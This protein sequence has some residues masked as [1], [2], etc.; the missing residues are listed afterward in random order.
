MTNVKDYM[1]AQES[2]ENSVATMQMNI[3]Q[4]YDK[5]LE[6]TRNGHYVDLSK[7]SDKESRK[8][9]KD[10]LVAGLLSPLNSAV[11]SLPEDPLF[12]KNLAMNSFYGFDET[13]LSKIVEDVKEGLT[14]E[15]FQG[16]LNQTRMRHVMQERMQAPQTMLDDISTE[17]LLDSI[18]VKAKD[19]KQVTLDDKVD[20][21]DEFRKQGAVSPKFL[22]DKSY[23]K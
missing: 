4:A 12:A 14:F 1:S 3:R 20:M 23:L 18:G 17:E 10:A 13:A 22:K 2:A 16:Y 15:Q 9:F 11:A 8:K 7:L 19:T 5:A 6:S 21:L